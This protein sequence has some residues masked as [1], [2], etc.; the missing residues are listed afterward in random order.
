MDLPGL[1]Q[2]RPA[3]KAFCQALPPFAVISFCWSIPPLIL[4]KIKIMNLHR[5]IFTALL[6]LL[7]GG[8]SCA[9]ITRSQTF[10]ASTPCSQGTRP[11]PGMAVS[12]SCELMKWKLTLSPDRF[13]LH[14]NYGIAKQGTKGFVDGGKTIDLEGH[15]VITKGMATDSNATVYRLTDNK[16]NKMIL[17]LK[18]GEDLLQVLD[19]DYHLMTGTAAW[20]YTLNRTAH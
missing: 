7:L 19:S 13:I 17:L 3:Q 18:L 6:L 9:Q 1:L 4:H 2:F 20:S 10:V 15:W 14:C 11:L 16:S 8:R 12:D 5:P